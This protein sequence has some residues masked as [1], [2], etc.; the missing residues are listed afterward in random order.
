VATLPEAIKLMGRHQLGKELSD[1]DVA[2][3]ATFLGTLTGT[4]PTEYVTP[5]VRR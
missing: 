1:A 5:P 2:S 3:I 4:L